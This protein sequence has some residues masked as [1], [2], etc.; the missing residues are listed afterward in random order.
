M[1][2]ISSVYMGIIYYMYYI[3]LLYLY[4]YGDDVPTIILNHSVHE[5]QMKIPPALISKDM[6]MGEDLQW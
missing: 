2:R 6:D 1:S 3:K 5:F 4:L